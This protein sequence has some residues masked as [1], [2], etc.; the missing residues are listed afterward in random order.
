MK[1]EFKELSE[2]LPS[3]EES[4]CNHLGNAC[5]PG[6][7]H[8]IGLFGGGCIKATIYSCCITKSEQEEENI[9]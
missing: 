8:I 4:V 5:L 3:C 9:T 1:L 2:K 6:F 7:R